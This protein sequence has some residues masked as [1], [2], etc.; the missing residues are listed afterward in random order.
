MSGIQKWLLRYKWL[1]PLGFTLG[2]VTLKSKIF[3]SV[4]LPVCRYSINEAELC[5]AIN[6]AVSLLDFDVEELKR[7]TLKLTYGPEY[8]GGVWANG[9]THPFSLV[10]VALRPDHRSWKRTLTHELGHVGLLS[11]G[12]D[13]DPNHRLKHYWAKS[14]SVE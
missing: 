1:I 6:E 2:T 9:C 4:E 12:S 14:D 8:C 11:K 5:V 13:G 3:K 7:Y 10:K